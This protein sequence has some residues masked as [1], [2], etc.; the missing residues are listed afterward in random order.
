MTVGQS[1]MDLLDWTGPDVQM[2]SSG[3]DHVHKDLHQQ[4]SYAVCMLI[5]YR[6]QTGPQ[7]D[8]QDFGNMKKKVIIE[9]SLKNFVPASKL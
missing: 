7:S 8:E 5:V 6:G 1:A 9:D 2:N 3:S 4:Q